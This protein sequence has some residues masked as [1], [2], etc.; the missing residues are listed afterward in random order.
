M[1][2]ARIK[3]AFAG[4][5]VS[6][7]DAGRPGLG[8]YGVP[9]SGPMDRFAHAAAQTALTRPAGA[10]A[11]EVSLGGLVLD[12]LEGAVSFA[13]AGG[14]FDVRLGAAEVGPWGVA[15][16]RPGDRLTLRGGP[17]G[18]WASLAFAG[19]LRAAAWLGATAT[20]TLSNLGG[21]A[22]RTGDILV[23]DGAA[24]LPAREGA[25]PPPDLARPTG[26]ARVVIGPQD[27]RFASDIV[28][29]F[30]AT[31]F[32]LTDA[33]DRMGV[34]LKGPSLPLADALSIPSEPVLRGSVQ[35]SG[36]GVPTL[37]L[38]DHGTTGGYP[39]IATVIAPD[40]DRVVQMRAGDLLRFVPV[41]PEA[42]I[43]ATRDRAALEAAWLKALAAPRA[44]LEERLM[45]ENL[46]GGSV[47][48]DEE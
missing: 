38:A 19:T 24:V 31:P 5:L 8:R 14:G 7:Q 1:T 16:L 23:I 13:V 42:A 45:C 35:V 28:E 43:A 12:C 11:L 27:D 10:A 21:G 32:A 29:T 36:D 48:G 3:V 6:V 9:M 41:A 34:R 15:T 37:L 26:T 44:T 20:H 30:L 47:T 33:F 22:V 39:K 46:I 17:W 4:P 2:S 25:I 18:S 40:L